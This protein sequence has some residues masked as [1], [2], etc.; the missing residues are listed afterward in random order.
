MGEINTGLRSILGDPRI[1]EALQALM[2]GGRRRQDFVDQY[3]RPRHGARILDIGCGPARLLKYLPESVEYVGYDTNARYVAWATRHYS[4]RG[5][6]IASRFDAAELE[7][8]EPFDIA[9]V[10]GVLHH[11]E[12][13]EAMDLFALLRQALRPGGRVITVDNVFESGQ[14]PIARKLIE[15][16]RGQNVR[17]SEGYK[18]LAEP[19][20][21]AVQG[22]V[23]HRSFVPYTYWIMECH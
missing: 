15:W 20:F 21:D 9:L 3:V 12:D 4:G 6:F 10:V 1:Y 13:R 22:T 7:R 16:D 18:V 17:T 14:N 8:H 11:L 2:G 5:Q 19:F 23:I